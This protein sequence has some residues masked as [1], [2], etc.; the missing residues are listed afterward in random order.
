[1]TVHFLQDVISHK[2]TARPQRV[3]RPQATRRNHTYT[4]TAA[5]QGRGARKY[6]KKFSK[7]IGNPAWKHAGVNIIWN[8]V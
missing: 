5:P 8:Q 3:N 2:A 1:M 7:A 6:G 4:T